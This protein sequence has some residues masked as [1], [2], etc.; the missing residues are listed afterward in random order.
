MA[1]TAT[2]HTTVDTFATVDRDR[3]LSTSERLLAQPDLDV[4]V[5]EDIFTID[6]GGMEWDIGAV[7]YEPT[8]PASIPDGAD[9]RKVGVFLLHGGAGDFKTMEG[10]ARFLAAKFGYRVVSGTFPGRFYFDDPSRDWPGD[11]IRKDGTVR[12]PIW[13]RGEHVTPEE[14][15]VVIDESMRGRYGRR[16][17]AKAKPGTP[18]RD[19][20][21]ASPLAMEAACKT[22][23][24]RHFPESE[25]SIY[26]HGHSTGGPLQFMMSQRL[27]NI[28]GVLAIEN[29]AFG[30]IN[31]AKHAW[32]GATKRVDP[33]DELSIRT[34]RDV[35][36]YR[37]PEAL[38]AE[39]GAVLNRLPWLMEDIFDEW[40]EAKKRPQFKCEYL[41]TWN[42][43]ASLK[44][45]AAH[46]AAR[47]RLSTDARAKLVDHYV[48][49]TRELTN[50]DARPV[51]AV[52]FG[53]SNN[54]RDHTPEVYE[55]AILPRFA[56]MRPAPL[57]TVI[58]F[59]GGT[60]SYADPEEGLPL[61]IAPAV[62]SSWDE[63]IRGGYFTAGPAR[64]E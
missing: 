56:A 37:G 20:L 22:A 47:L 42:I 48:G 39:G 11:T 40:A 7:R 61:G 36:R 13:R 5:T 6:V 49:M 60:H 52:L 53:V 38:G 15:D 17:L 45:A 19:R 24:E 30:Y 21:A 9:G 50:A 25:F 28:E 26:V 16:T 10:R 55:Q 23:M 63:A 1:A 32:A 2:S 59:E 54:S 18:F 8:D 14:Y 35:A 58:R 33:F 46:T 57:V 43:V 64:S 27:P 41:V 44:A 4:D 34:W 62:F 31:E 29:S 3:L 51:P 12:T